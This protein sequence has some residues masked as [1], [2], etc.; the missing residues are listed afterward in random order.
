MEAVA[1][2]VS[3]LT[4]YFSG[5]HTQLRPWVTIC[6]FFHCMTSG[7]GFVHVWWWR[8][9]LH[10]GWIPVEHCWEVSPWALSLCQPL[11]FFFSHF[12]SLTQAFPQQSVWFCLG[13]ITSCTIRFVQFFA[14]SKKTKYR[15]LISKDLN[16]LENL[17]K[18][19]GHKPSIYSTMTHFMSC[20]N[21]T[22]GYIRF[23]K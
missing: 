16:F 18:A 14:G 22:A 21:Q 2:H 17:Q 5:S 13:Y 1:I 3:P 12:C 20:F 19:L 7:K 11:L 15:S 10:V 23:I 6:L 9:H 8:F 4:V